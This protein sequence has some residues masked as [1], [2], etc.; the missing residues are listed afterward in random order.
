MS[1]YKAF[2]A[3]ITSTFTY[4]THTSHCQIAV[5]AKFNSI[6]VF[7]WD[8]GYLIVG[9]FDCVTEQNEKEGEAKGKEENYSSSSLRQRLRNA[10]L[11]DVFNGREFVDNVKTQ[12]K[13]IDEAFYLGTGEVHV[14]TPYVSY[15]V[16]VLRRCNP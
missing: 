2:R 15:G 9:F 14:S 6:P 11:G 1:R 5:G 8:V 12:R 4:L 3:S 13:G 7:A 16:E 10:K